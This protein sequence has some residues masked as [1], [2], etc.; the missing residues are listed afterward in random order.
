MLN[1]FVFLLIFLAPFNL[2]LKFFESDA[3][4]NGIFVDYLVVKV[5]LVEIVALVF[6]LWQA[7]NLKK[8]FKFLQKNI[9]LLLVILLLLARQFFVASPVVAIWQFF[10]FVEF[11]LLGFLLWEN[12][13]LISGKVAKWALVSAIIF[14]VVLSI[15]QFAQQRPALPYKFIGETQFTRSINV[16]RVQFKTIQKIPPHGTTAHP[17]ILA[18]V[19]VIYL[20]ILLE[21]FGRFRNWKGLI[22]VGVISLVTF[23]TQ[24]YSAIAFLALYLLGK[25]FERFKWGGKWESKKWQIFIISIIAIPILIGLSQNKFPQNTSLTRR[26]NLNKQAVQMFFE[27]PLDGV[28]MGQFTIE[29]DQQSGEAIRFIQPVHHVGLLWLA[30]TGLLGLILIF[31]AIKICKNSPV[32][33]KIKLNYFWVIL[34]IPIIALDHYLMTQWV[35]LWLLVFIIF[36][37]E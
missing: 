33:K 37:P 4:V 6:I 29:L 22:L 31:L 5:Y 35:G 10:R 36:L 12:R 20:V 15:F 9:Y 27:N 28:G 1:A 30:E 23:W 19:L 34:L 17:N 24:S 26:A 21:K 7:K 2:F 3:Y 8:V 25:N 32:S 16:S 11:A 13:K 14:Q 18:G